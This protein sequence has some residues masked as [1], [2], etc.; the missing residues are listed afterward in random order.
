MSLTGGFV[1]KLFSLETAESILFECASYNS[2]RQNFLDCLKQVLALEVFEAFCFNSIFDKA[3][4][5]LG[6]K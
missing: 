4:F 2:Q 5:C 6:E 1:N 3:V